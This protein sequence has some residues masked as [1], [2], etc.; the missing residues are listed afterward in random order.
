MSVWRLLPSGFLMGLGVSAAG[1]VT[2]FRVLLVRRPNDL[3]NWSSW[4]ALRCTTSRRSCFNIIWIASISAQ[5]SVMRTITC[6]VKRCYQV[7]VLN[8][9]IWIKDKY[10][11]SRLL[12][13]T[14]SYGTVCFFCEASSWNNAGQEGL[15]TASASQWTNILNMMLN[16]S[17][18]PPSAKLSP[19]YQLPV[20]LFT[21]NLYRVFSAS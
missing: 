13:R 18:I 14:C 2:F 21:S 20:V 16:H 11:K 8:W 1:F 19:N 9:W 5:L 17:F 7:S 6:T 4:N 3:F 12:L 10:I 15:L